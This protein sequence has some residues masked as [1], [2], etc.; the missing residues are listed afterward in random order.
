[1]QQPTQRRMAFVNQAEQNPAT[2]K[3]APPAAVPGQ[4]FNSE[5]KLVASGVAALK[6]EIYKIARGDQKKTN[7][8][9]NLFGADKDLPKKLGAIIDIVNKNFDP[10]IAE[11]IFDAISVKYTKRQDAI[12]KIIDILY[13]EDGKKLLSWQ[14]P[15]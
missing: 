4:I 9:M 14:V 15:Q 12:D 5:E 7:A 13:G 6:Q 3:K 2:L 11:K 8:A 1:M 10:K